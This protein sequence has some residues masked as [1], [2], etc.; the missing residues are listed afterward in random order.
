MYIHGIK[1]RLV[2]TGYKIADQSA[3]YYLTFQIVGWVDLFTRQV[4][5]DIVIESLRYCQQ[6]KGLV[7]Y[8]YVIMSNHIHLLA[9]SDTDNLSGTICDFKTFTSRRIMDTIHNIPE[10]RRELMEMVFSFHGKYKDRQNY[11]I[12]TYDNHAEHVYSNKFFSQ[13]VTYIHDNPVRSRIVEASH[14]YL[15]SSAQNYSGTGSI[16]DVVCVD[17]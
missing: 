10:R 5:R 8:A 9:S 3:A 6:N 4:Y 2:T 7:V 12:W 16:L 11:Q 15:Y 1:I 17:L 14:H 13:K